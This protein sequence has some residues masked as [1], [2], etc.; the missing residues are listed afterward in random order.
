[1]RTCSTRTVPRSAITGWAIVASFRICSLDQSSNS[2]VLEN[3]KTNTE[4]LISCGV[5]S[6]TTAPTEAMFVDAARVRR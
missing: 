4:P 5:N 6:A 2:L 1:M 3:S